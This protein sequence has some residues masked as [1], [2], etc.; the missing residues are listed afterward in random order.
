MTLGLVGR[1]VGMTRVFDEQGASVPVTV[2]DMSANRVTQIKSKDTDGYTAVQ[3]TFGRKKA[4]R[5]N[6]AEGGHFAK[7]GVEAGRGLAEFVVSEEKLA[8]LNAG[9]EVTVGIFEAGQLVDI[10]GTGKGKGFS[11][12]I[13]RHNFDSQRTSHGNS[14]SHRVPGSIGMAQD[15]GRVFKGKRMAGQY[16]NTQSTVQNLQ[17]VRVDAD[18]QLLLVKGAV[19][20]AVNSD[21]VVRHSVKAGA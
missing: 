19:P 5:V 21:V 12:T 4:N 7:A 13:K 6:K 9:D 16:G 15:P 8:E 20:G 18:R 14:R 17:I 11:G 10:T 2:L 1:K 3:V